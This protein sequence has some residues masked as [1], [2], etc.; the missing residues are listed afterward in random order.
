MREVSHRV[1]Y[2][3]DHIRQIFKKKYPCCC[4]KIPNQSPVFELDLCF[5]HLL[6]FL[7]PRRGKKANDMVA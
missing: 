3:C 6:A 1:G 5:C 4:Q 2:M 7:G